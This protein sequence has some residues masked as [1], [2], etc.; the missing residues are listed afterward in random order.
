M[1][2]DSYHIEHYTAPSGR[3]FKIELSYDNFSGAPWE[4]GDSYGIVSEWTARDKRSGELILHEDGGRHRSRL[5]YDYKA[6]MQR[7]KQDGWGHS[8]PTDPDKPET[9]GQIAHKAVMEDFKFLQGW[10]K[11]D[12][13][14]CYLTV[15]LLNTDGTPNTDY[16]DVC[17]GMEDGYTGTFRENLI[18]EAQA[19][20]KML[21]RSL[22]NTIQQRHSKPCTLQ[23]F[24]LITTVKPQYT[25]QP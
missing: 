8:Q 20:A 24:P 10:C 22:S 1:T 25:I 14:Y 6:T 18:A 5:Y 17:G 11:Q 2:T 7:A 12:W 13:F 15:T 16:E 21:D 23:H 9:A 19:T 4:D 3:T